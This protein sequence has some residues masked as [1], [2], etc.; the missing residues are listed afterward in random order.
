VPKLLY[1]DGSLA[2]FQEAWREPRTKFVQ[3]FHAKGTLFQAGMEHP[4]TRD[5]IPRHQEIALALMPDL[6]IEVSRWAAGGDDVF[7]E[8]DAS[9]TFQ[10]HRQRW[11]GASRFTLRDGLI[12][13]EIAYFDTAPLRLVAHAGFEGEMTGAAMASI[14]GG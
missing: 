4:I 7:I 1:D 11:S 9:G 6:A 14:A 10:G 8:W 2:P 12:V 3:L 5:A 13:E